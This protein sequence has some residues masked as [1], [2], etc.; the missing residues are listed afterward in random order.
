[1]L[2]PALKSRDGG[3]LTKQVV[4]GE[5]DLGWGWGGAH[6]RF[7]VGQTVDRSRGG[8]AGEAIGGAGLSDGA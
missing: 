4:R 7:G 3:G 6:C 1:M 8:G 2:T 5:D